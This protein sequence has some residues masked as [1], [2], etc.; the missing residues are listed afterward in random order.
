MP[1]FSMTNFSKTKYIVPIILL[2]AT[3]QVAAAQSSAPLTG[4]YACEAISK[5]KAQL[6][7]FLKETAK[8][9]AAETSGD[10]VA[11]DKE[12]FTEIK[13]AEVKELEVEEYEKKKAETNKNQR[14][15]IRGARRFGGSRFFRFTLENG[16]VWQQTE[17]GHVRLGKGNP[18]ILTIQRTSFGGHIGKVNDKAPAIRIKKVR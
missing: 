12:R 1:S 11:V 5:K 2:I 14:L 4:L 6:S 16:E 9:R 3:P 18:D 7:C 13:K 8:L 10:I 17:A 15:A